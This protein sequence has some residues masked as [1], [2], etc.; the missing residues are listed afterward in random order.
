M[1]YLMHQKFRGETLGTV[2]SL[3]DGL[4]ATGRRVNFSSQTQMLTQL[5]K[6]VH[7]ASR[8]LQASEKAAAGSTQLALWGTPNLTQSFAI[9]MT[10]ISEASSWQS[11]FA[12]NVRDLMQAAA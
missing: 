12:G 3:H 9:C 5:A 1:I 4:Q 7:Y 2:A 11:T 6:D 10:G 8:R